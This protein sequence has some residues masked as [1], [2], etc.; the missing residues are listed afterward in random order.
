VLGN[1]DYLVEVRVKSLSDAHVL[2]SVV[3][4]AAEVK[5]ALGCLIIE[6]D[7]LGVLSQGVKNDLAH[8]DEEGDSVHQTLL[9]LYLGK[10]TICEEHQLLRIELVLVPRQESADSLGFS[11]FLAVGPA[12]QLL[13]LIKA[14]L[15]LA[16]FNG[17]IRPIL[18]LF[19]HVFKQ[20][21]IGM[22]ADISEVA[23]ILLQ[24]CGS[25]VVSTEID[26]FDDDFLENDVVSAE[27]LPVQRQVK[28][29]KS[30][31]DITL[32]LEF[33]SVFER[34]FMRDIASHYILL[35]YL[36]LQI[37]YYIGIMND[38]AFLR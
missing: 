33:H 11:V 27:F 9:R 25:E 37:T 35:L 16:S 2:H 26:H 22:L 13:K 18:K 31:L 32:L 7:H 10:A 4:L 5:Y 3:V 34:I 1:L 23:D 38:P 14:M 21:H 19:Q 6:I 15:L 28:L 29:L 20:G 36:I 12:K 30:T 8:I 17:I 24:I